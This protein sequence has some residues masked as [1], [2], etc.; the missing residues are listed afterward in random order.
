MLSVVGA[1][2]DPMST[3]SA[4]HS[5]LLTV[6]RIEATVLMS[7]AIGQAGL[8]AGFLSGDGGLEPIH[9]INAYVLLGTTVVVTATAALYRR[10]GGPRWPVLAG[11]ILLLVETGQLVLAGLDAVGLH[12]FCGVLFVVMATLLTSYLFRPG[13]VSA[14]G[15]SAVKG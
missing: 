3:S 14:T 12:I 5:P 9:G 11:V 13:F 7:L 2:N 8:A 4:P 1:H 6:L 10:A 15:N